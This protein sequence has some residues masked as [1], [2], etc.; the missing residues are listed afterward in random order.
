MDIIKTIAEIFYVDK[1]RF[2]DVS[3]NHLYELAKQKG[4]QD[5]L[6]MLFEK[7]YIERLHN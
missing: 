3:D 7:G 6:K 2:D 1:M 4:H 5:V